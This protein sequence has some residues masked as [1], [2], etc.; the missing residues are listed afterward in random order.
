[1]SRKPFHASD[2]TGSEGPG[3]QKLRRAAAAPAASPRAKGQ[4]PKLADVRHYMALEAW[5]SA[6]LAAARFPDLGD[7]A[8]AIHRGR[9]AILRPAFQRQLR[10]DPAQMIE[11]A[12]EALRARWPR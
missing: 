10:R 3:M 11:E 1:M 7:H 8:A 12:K 5:E 2:F 6:I 9:E 4:G